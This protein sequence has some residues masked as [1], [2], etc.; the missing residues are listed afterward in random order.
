M[1]APL[2]APQAGYVARVDAR[3]IG[4][5]VVGLGGGRTRKEDAVDPAVG[6]RLS[7]H[8]KIGAQVEAGQP[9]LWVH[10]RSDEDLQNALSRLS[11]AYSYSDQPVQPPTLIHHIIREE[12]PSARS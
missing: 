4:F 7:P 10:A 3:E 8:A 11:S 5:T 6:V 12:E 1:V 9:L 2:L